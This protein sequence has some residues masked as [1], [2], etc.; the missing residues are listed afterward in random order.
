MC[1][2]RDSMRRAGKH[3][4]SFSFESSSLRIQECQS[5]CFSSHINYKEIISAQQPIVIKNIAQNWPAISSPDRRWESLPYLVKAC[6]QCMVPVEIGGD[7]MNSMTRIEIMKLSQVLHKF[8]V[9][10]F[11][12]GDSQQSEFQPQ[13]Y[14]LAQ[15][16]LLS[17]DNLINDIQIPEICSSHLV[18]KNINIWI[19]N[20]TSSSP[21]HHD[22]YE[23]ILIQ[24]FGQK[25]ILL[26]PPADTKYLYPAPIPQRNTSRINFKND[27]KE[28]MK[29]FPLLSQASGYHATLSPGDGLFIPFH[30]WHYCQ[31]RSLNC[32]V[33]FWWLEPE[34]TPKKAP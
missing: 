21:C 4:S 17:M 30:W 18:G 1:T 16:P 25:S 2:V 9:Q 13:H 3:F 19:G 11:S 24:I 6:G 34:A 15:H 7:Y 14:Y 22:P 10:K 8:Q 29:Q 33:N 31:A 26:F 27:L 5:I 20:L 28:E 23:N 12:K 32:S